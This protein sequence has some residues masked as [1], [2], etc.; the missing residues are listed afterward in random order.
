MNTYHGNLSG[1]NSVFLK[2]DLCKRS[3]Q[4][5]GGTA[6]PFRSLPVVLPVN[7]D[8]GSR[9]PSSFF[10]GQAFPVFSSKSEEA[11]WNEQDMSFR[12]KTLIEVYLQE[13]T[14]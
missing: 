9:F 13:R 2:R 10:Q 5:A 1:A 8:E 11:L 14:R 4:I 12:V 3:A 7:L 6:L